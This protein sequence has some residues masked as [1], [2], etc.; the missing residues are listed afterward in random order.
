M[1]IHWRLLL[2]RM[3]QAAEAAVTVVQETVEVT[4]AAETVA[5]AAAAPVEEAAV[6]NPAA[7]DRHPVLIPVFWILQ[8]KRYR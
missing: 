1:R 7:P 5:P 2:M 3:S 6:T 4:A 8:T